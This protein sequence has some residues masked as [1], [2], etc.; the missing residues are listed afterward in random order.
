MAYTREQ[1]A[2]NAAKAAAQ[3]AAAAKASQPSEAPA[4]PA[5]ENA[6]N[7]DAPTT[8]PRYRNDD[9]TAA[10]AE[11]EERHN[12]TSGNSVPEPEEE[13]P[14]VKPEPRRAPPKAE[15]KPDPAAPAPAQEPAQ[16]PVAA[17]EE[18]PEPVEMV[19]V[20]VDGEEFQVSKADIDDAGGVRAYQTMRAA[21][22]R[23]KKANETLA[24]T[25]QT[26]AQLAE[27][28]RAALTPKAPEQP[29]KSKAEL[30]QAI[31]FGSEDEAD[32]AL[33]EIT[34]RGR[35]QQVDQ[36]QLI[37][38]TVTETN[39]NSAVSQFQ[40]EFSDIAG[41]AIILQ[42]AVALDKQRI[43]AAVQNGT[44]GPQFDFADHYRKIGNEVRSAFG[45]P[46]QPA[47]ALAAPTAGHPSPSSANKEERKASIVNLPTAQARAELPAEAKPDTREET[48][49]S[50]RKSRGQSTI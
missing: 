16:E 34:S 24:A 3:A 39:K 49:N 22:N 21:D 50:Y 5:T 35:G 44:Y 26:Q 38:M 25:R 13:E 33:E 4:E 8:R 19:T 30:I 40:R 9:R 28:A 6:A 48:L 15:Q 46:S 42:A 45:R 11:I 37:A 12:R 43:S 27:F 17:P 47:P 10:F 36:N 29:K 7:L 18:T 31:R 14:E 2:A 20:K 32:A 41:N 23:L 1:R